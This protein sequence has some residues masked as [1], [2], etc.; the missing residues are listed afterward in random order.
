MSCVFKALAAFG[1]LRK[2]SG[3]E[4]AI[5]MTFATPSITPLLVTEAPEI[6]STFKVCPSMICLGIRVKTTSAIPCD[7]PDVSMS[8]ASMRLLSIRTTIGISPLCPGVVTVNSPEVKAT[9]SGSAKT[10]TT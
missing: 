3:F 5:L 4:P 6:I 2:I 1:R 9:S 7:S 8:I 10:F